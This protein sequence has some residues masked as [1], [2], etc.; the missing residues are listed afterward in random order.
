[1]TTL[2]N[3]ALEL[4]ILLFKHTQN[5]AIDDGQ[6]RGKL[7]EDLD[8][9]TVEQALETIQ[10]LLSANAT[11]R[12]LEWHLPPHFF[13]SLDHLLNSPARRITP[14]KRF[15]LADTDTLFTGNETCLPANI[16][17]YLAATRLFGLLS[18][19][20]DHHGGI[21]DSKTLVFLQQTK[22]EITPQYGLTDLTE[23]KDLAAFETEFIT[24]QAH[25]EQKRSIIK[26]VLFEQFSGTNR[27][28]FGS[29]LHRFDDFFEKVQAS[30][31]LYTAEFSFQKVKTEIEK[32]KLDA[33][34]KLNKVFSDV[35]SQLLT[36]P[37]ALVLVGGQLEDKGAWSNKNL[38]I[39]LGALVFA[40]LMDLLIRNQ[41]HTLTAV[42][43]EI[44][45]QRQQ[46]ENKYHSVANRFR[47][48]YREID[49]RYGHQLRLIYVV[50]FL[51]AM[52]LGA[53]TFMFIKFCGGY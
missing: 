52:S 3:D 6:L 4:A 35:Q 44:D 26:T 24:S 7:S 49:C 1:M 2:P 15:Y 41:R 16:R 45:Q 25:Q 5:P 31:E 40:V 43:Q 46:I 8:F 42:K 32:E 38:L 30:Y 28:P 12:T 10:L 17:Q 48:S 14:P 36:V 19:V 50:D 22:V 18:K 21:G 23:L 13:Q 37:V 39:W 33:M 20:A 11:T 9:D 27:L 47:G 29:V 53:T 34:I 51:V